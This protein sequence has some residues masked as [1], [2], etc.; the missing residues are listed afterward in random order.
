MAKW[1]WSHKPV[2]CKQ[3]GEEFPGCEG[4]EGDF[5]SEGCYNTYMLPKVKDAGKKTLKRWQKNVEKM[6][7]KISRLEDALSSD[8]VEAIKSA[9][10]IGL[11]GVLKFLFLLPSYLWWGFVLLGIIYCF[12]EKYNGASSIPTN[13]GTNEVQIV[14]QQQSTQEDSQETDEGDNASKEKLAE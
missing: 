2:R 9:S 14:E 10:S 1:N 6:N 3:C 8:S 7:R 11:M 13:A 4:Y 12:Y 5:C